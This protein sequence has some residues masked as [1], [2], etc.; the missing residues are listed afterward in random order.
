MFGFDVFAEIMV[1][2]G[3]LLLALT[4]LFV[5]LSPWASREGGFLPAVDYL[6]EGT[7][8]YLIALFV[9]YALGIAGNRLI[10]DGLEVFID[11]GREHSNAYR[12]W[13][14]NK[15]DRAKTLKLAEFVL[16]ERSD[17][18]ANWLDRHKSFVRVLRGAAAATV[19]LLLTMLAYELSKPPRPRYRRVHFLGALLLL[20]IFS[21]AYY[22]EA[23]AYKKRVH[24][25]S[26]DLPARVK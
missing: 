6:K 2:G 20:L 13:A 3:L 15:P 8:R 24:D 12:D 25:L 10:D 26:I 7:G 17:A 16:K 1:V 4:P 19:L 23:S 11:P 9:A 5:R 14:V 22:L 21:L 18:V